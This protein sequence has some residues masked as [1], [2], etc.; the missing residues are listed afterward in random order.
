M[1]KHIIEAHGGQISVRSELGRGTTWTI[2]AGGTLATY[3]WNEGRMPSARLTVTE[4]NRYYLDIAA[5]W[6]E[7]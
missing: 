1:S 7:P 4:V 5:R 2:Y 6:E 3:L